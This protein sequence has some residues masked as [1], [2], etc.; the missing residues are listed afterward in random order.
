MSTG[1]TT[2]IPKMV[3]YWGKWFGH[4][5]LMFSEGVIEEVATL[6]NRLIRGSIATPSRCSR[7]DA[8]VFP[9]KLGGANACQ[10][11]KYT[12]VIGRTVKTYLIGYLVYF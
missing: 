8:L 5:F 3:Q 11:F 6:G 1:L 7:S 9:H 12:V 4:H 10:R 2:G